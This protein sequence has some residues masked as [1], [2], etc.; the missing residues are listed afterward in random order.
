VVSTA[1]SAE[2]KSV[3][4]VLFF[5]G[6]SVVGTGRVGGRSTRSRVRGRRGSVIG[7]TRVLRQTRWR[8]LAFSVGTG[9]IGRLGVPFSFRLGESEIDMIDVDICVNYIVPATRSTFDF[10][11]TEAKRMDV[12]KRMSLG[13]PER[14]DGV[15]CAWRE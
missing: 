12:I 3:M 8:W 15:I 5:L 9:F 1:E 6:D 10:L 13:K 4:A 11:Q 14:E 2:A 7:R